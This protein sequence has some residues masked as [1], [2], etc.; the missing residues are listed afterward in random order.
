MSTDD[1]QSSKTF[2]LRHRAEEMLRR[3]PEVGN[4][5]D[6]DMLEL[7]HELEV[8]QAELE[9]QNEE[10]R[11]AQGEIAALHREFEDLYEFA[12]CGYVTLNPKGIITRCN[13]SGVTLLGSERSVL[14]GIGFSSFVAPDRR[15]D[16]WAAL[17][18]AGQSGGKESV[19][20]KLARAESEPVWV[21]ADILANRTEGGGVSQW[22]LALVDIVER[23]RLEKILKNAKEQWEGTFDAISDWVCILDKDHKIVRS[24]GSVDR[25]CGYSV[26]EVIGRRCYEV[27]HGIN[28][29]VAD[30]PVVR[31]LR[32]R[33]REEAEFQTGDGRWL[34]VSV[35]PIE[36]GDHPGELFV[37]IVQDITSRKLIEAEKAKLEAQN[38]QLQKAESLGRMAGAVAHHFNNM[39][40]AAIGNLD[41]A[42]DD[43]PEGSEARQSIVESKRASL[44]ASEISRLML[45]YLGQTTG[46]REPLDLAQ[47]VR[48]TIQ[49]VGASASKK[50]PFKIQLPPLGPVILGDSVHIRQ[51]LTNLVSNALEAMEDRD[52]EITVAATVAM[53]T[54]I[55]GLRFF[56]L[57]WEPRANGYACLSIA[58][59]GGGM[60]EVTWERLFDPFF[61]TKF[62]G[63]GLGL[64][65]VLGLVRAHEGAVNV[66]SR[67][68][69]G[70]V[71]RVF[72]P[73]HALDVE[74]SEKEEPVAAAPSEKGG[75]VLVVDDEPIIRSMTERMLTRKLG[76][77]VITAKDGS[78]AVAIFRER[79][80]D[81]RM[82][83]L[84]LSMPGMNGWETLA[85]LR[86]LRPDIPVV[87]ASGHD[88]AR[89]MQSA[90]SDR[91]QAFLHKPYQKAEL[92][93]AIAAALS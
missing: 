20:L 9:I 67:P 76:Y 65:V 41:L 77:E 19:E 45:T 22:R 7:I 52:G 3:R 2:R 26:R 10:L 21:L 87:L 46:K 73:L 79:R 78:E 74:A 44:R 25:F 27:V 32:N 12:P 17:Q 64:A 24:N 84:D 42:L 33:Q 1:D 36:Y 8:H 51:I 71:F 55:Q 29:P 31:A 72:F 93:A 35:D 62:T 50:V 57:D 92:E 61:S 88:E 13:L 18:R 90:H 34:H 69:Q 56:P 40:G 48:E 68:G 6:A 66:E 4:Q 60:D 5:T 39:L 53:A 49:I 81:I 59:T 70:S 37:Y 58:D 30:C 80:E 11:R 23:K 38:R 54:E 14:K 28:H 91:P 82:V 83:L 63:R 43:L 15:D 75:L 16:F 47:A 85:A 89:V 86:A